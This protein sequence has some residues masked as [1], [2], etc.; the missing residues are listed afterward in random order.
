MIRCRAFVLLLLTSSLMLSGCQSDTFGREW[1]P[2]RIKLTVEVETPEGVRTG[3]SV[4][5]RVC[6]AAGMVL[7]T[8][9]G[10]MCSVQGE[11]VAVDLP[12][13]ETLFV[14][15]STPI[16]ASWQPE[17]NIV[18][19][20]DPWAGPGNRIEQMD[21]YVSMMSRNRVPSPV[22][23]SKQPPWFVRFKDMKDPK[24]VEE[25]DP[26][27]LSKSFGKGYRLRAVTV[28]GTDEPMTAGIGKRLGE[29]RIFPDHSLDNDFV[30]TTT[31][32]LAQKLG[33]ADFLQGMKK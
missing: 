29:L 4:T 2:F 23:L 33:F 16:S 5:E 12:K 21:R 11:A 19:P 31:P 20:S 3:Y 28:Q 10:S 8:Q 13:G 26:A 30:S 14:L 6:G 1:P 25:V 7:G 17:G 15:L 9:G 22:D 18:L 27:D 24:S 32:T